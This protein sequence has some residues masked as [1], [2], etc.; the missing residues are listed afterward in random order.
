MAEYPD[1]RPP[2]P[3]LS[4]LATAREEFLALRDSVNGAMLATLSK[5]GSPA[6]SYAPLIWSDGNC[7]LFLSALA[8]HTQNLKLCP[9][10]GLMLAEPEKKAA[11]F[12]R[13]R[14]TLQ[15]EA[16]TVPR[17]T[18]EFEKVLACFHQRF[19]KVMSIIEPLP[20]FQLF[21]ISL[22]EGRFVRGFGQAYALSGACLDELTHIGAG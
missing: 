10:I 22:K 11:A 2:S 14:I 8:E 20:D 4:E 18:A 5:D 12:A 17:Q 15:G 16:R 13:K 7:Y 21:R 1:P 6:A 19:G 3:V 9:S